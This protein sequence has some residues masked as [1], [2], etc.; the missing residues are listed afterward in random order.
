VF[1]SCS[2]GFGYGFGPELVDDDSFGYF[3]KR[4]SRFIVMEEI[5]DDSMNLYREL[6]PAI[7]THIMELMPEYRL[8]YDKAN[9][10]VYE[11]IGS[12]TQAAASKN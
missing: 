9:Y 2:W 7:Y 3:S 1:A 10:R 5:Y 11:R 6:H 4:Q 12:K 8:V